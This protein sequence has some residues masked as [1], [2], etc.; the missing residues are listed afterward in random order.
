MYSL[1]P[2]RQGKQQNF[3]VCEHN[4]QH[5]LSSF[6]VTSADTVIRTCRP[7]EILWAATSFFTR[8]RSFWL[9]ESK[10]VVHITHPACGPACLAANREG[11]RDTQH[12][13]CC[14][15]RLDLLMQFHFHEVAQVCGA[16]AT[17]MLMPSFFLLSLGG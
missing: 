3:Q 13:C 17:T 7:C 10:K 14:P 2:G 6:T 5:F 12:P 4:D 16:N 9:C 8:V 1:E 15:F 11:Y